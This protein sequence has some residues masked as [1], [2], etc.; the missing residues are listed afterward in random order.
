MTLRIQQEIY[1]IIS[2][3][4]VIEKMKIVLC[5]L[6]CH[7]WQSSAIRTTQSITILDDTSDNEDM[8]LSAL[9]Q[10]NSNSSNSDLA[11][12]L[13]QPSEPSQII[14]EN[15]QEK[16]IHIPKDQILQILSLMG[17]L[18]ELYSKTENSITN[19][20]NSSLI[21]LT[22]FT[23]PRFENNPNN[24]NGKN[25]IPAR[26]LNK[27]SFLRKTFLEELERRDNDGSNSTITINNSNYDLGNKSNIQDT[28][29]WESNN[30]S[31][32]RRGEIS[33]HDFLLNVISRRNE[34]TE[35]RLY[36]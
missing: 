21:P 4:P 35:I 6:L 34:N 19:T 3:I 11:T 26:Y 30:I 25:A 1:R 9:D 2:E 17:T 16:V 7:S 5:F 18:K 10:N 32:T 20:E 12:G 27:L 23:H 33:I 36:R 31:T 13:K 8:M 22:N 29:V 28:N 15:I 14:S 24:F